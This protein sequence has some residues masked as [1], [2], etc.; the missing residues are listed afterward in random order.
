MVEQ[1]GVRE[2]AH[3]MAVAVGQNFKDTP[4][5]DRHAFLAQPHLQLP[6][7]L[8]VGLRKQISEVFG[9]GGVVFWRFGHG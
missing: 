6:V 9:D 7:D 8:P 4:L 1:H 5:L 2:F 3:G